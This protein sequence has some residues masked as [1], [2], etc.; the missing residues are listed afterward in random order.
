MEFMLPIFSILTRLLLLCRMGRHYYWGMN[1]K[2]YALDV[3]YQAGTSGTPNGG[4]TTCTGTSGSALLTCTSATDL[5]QGQRISIGTDINEE[6]VG[7]NATNP[8]AVVVN[9]GSNL[10]STYSTATALSFT[11]PVLGPEIQMPTKSLSAPTTLAWSQGDM[12]QNSAAT[13]NGVAAWVN[14]A[15]GTPGT[16]AGIPLGNSSGQINT[17]QI[18]TVQGSDSKVMTAGTVSGTGSTL[19]TDANGGATTAGCSGASTS[20]RTAYGACTGTATSSSSALYLFNLGAPTGACTVT[21]STN[22]INAPV[23]TTTGTL[24]KLTVRCGT[25]GVSSSSGVFTIFDAPS[26]TAYTGSST[27][28]TVT[29]G[30]TA[31][32]TMVQDTTHTYNYAV[33]DMITVRFTT[34]ASET[35]GGCT[36]SFNY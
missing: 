33:G 29:Y 31:A 1:G 13:T 25:T 14:V 10:A 21:Y 6:I 23:M 17:S 9:L 12:E 15:G 11:A 2:R 16:W 30:T 36:A 3:V 7:V 19:C 5:S 28:I 27:G 35:L 18:S 32:N 20:V 24:S 4:A 8:T 34:Q 26:G 22:N